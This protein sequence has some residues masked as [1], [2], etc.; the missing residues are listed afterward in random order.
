[1]CDNLRSNS[2]RSFVFLVTFFLYAAYGS[3]YEII[4][5]VN[6][7]SIAGRVKFAGSVTPP[8]KVEI[9][10]DRD[11]CGKTEKIDESILVGEDRGLQ[12][13]LV[14]ILEIQK[15]KVF[16]DS[17]PILDQ[18]DCRY[19][20]HLV[21]VPVGKPL[22]ILNNDG[23]LHSVHTHSVKNPAF[24]RAQSK[25]KTEMQEILAYPEIIKLTCDVHSWMSGWIIVQEHPYFTVSGENGF[26]ELLDVPPGE[27]V[28]SFWHEVL[29][30][31]EISL[32]VEP[33]KQTFILEI[34]INS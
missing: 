23:V 9:S 32:V 25:F 15:G 19:V 27:Y 11:E 1:M 21:L 7:G 24:N 33:D 29:G 2:V 22:T 6:G 12:N 26:F 3:A 13:V 30:I 20:P 28:V 14:S 10:K 31:K 18:R 34:F 5:V 16:T 8:Q 17:V 4:T